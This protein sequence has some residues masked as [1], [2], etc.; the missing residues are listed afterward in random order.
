MSLTRPSSL[1]KPA[2]VALA[3]R[4]VEVVAAD[5]SGP[6]EQLVD[7]LKGVDTLISAVGAREQFAQIPLATAAKKAG[8]KRFVPCAFMT[9][10]PPRGV[11]QLRDWVSL[12]S[13]LSHWPPVES[14]K[15]MQKEDVYNHVKKI[16]LPYTIIDV[17]WWY[18][19]S[20][21]R[22]PSGKVDYF[23]GPQ[24]MFNNLIN[25]GNQPSALTDLRDIGIYVAAII[26]D[27]RTINKY[28]LAY[29]ELL[30]PNEV[31]DKFERL[32]GEHI[33]REYIPEAQLRQDHALAAS[34]LEKDP[35]SF[36]AGFLLIKN[37]Y[38]I[39]FGARGDNTPE[40]AKYLGYL[41]SKDLY[42]DLGFRGFESFL[43]DLLEGK[44]K[45]I[46]QD[47]LMAQAV[48]EVY[49]SMSQ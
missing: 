40:Y 15:S 44:V 18:Q 38:A 6:E 29:S 42:P 14:N 22:L 25:D 16:K 10:G 43:G 9:V 7:L 4:G 13:P 49:G 48:S 17:G 8:V 41:T 37:E 45:G 3:A 28:V 23:T 19:V 30:S 24:T 21:P 46:Y 32:S 11:M 35:D 26:A 36:V 47:G 12:S 31:Y 2:N 39:S 20:I 5:L 33:P 34:A 1:D 27:G